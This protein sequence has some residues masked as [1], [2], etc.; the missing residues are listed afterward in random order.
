MRLRW[1]LLSTASINDLI[2]ESC[3]DSR[4]VE[5][6]AVASRQLERAQTYASARGIPRAFGSYEA[7]LADPDVDAIYV[8]LPNGLHTEWSQAALAAGKHV[9][10]EKP[11]TRHADEIEATYGIAEHAGRVFG[12][13]F[14]YRHHPQTEL[15]REVVA[16]GRLGTPRF[17]LSSHSFLM[18]PEE[19]ARRLPAELD[20]GAL[21]DLG[22][23]QIGMSRLLAGGEPEE[24]F[25]M[26]V[27]H[28][29]GV[30]MRFAAT[31]RFGG[32]LIAQFDCA[33]DV[34]LRN[35]LEVVGA[36]ATLTVSD[37]WHCRGGTIALR[38][39]GGA[40][41]QLAVPVGDAYRLEFEA[42]ARAVA[43]ERVAAFD[44][45]EAIAQARAIT[46][47][48]GSAQ[49]GTVTALA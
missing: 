39:E 40:V 43:G 27:V 28:E 35:A 24:V 18:P 13:A 20:A 29:T 5:V 11:L 23:Y 26:Q 34:P 36:E 32:G 25:G 48:Y 4:A 6:A 17:V 31:L 8:S 21:M 10:C 9:L 1:G 45:A 42:F 19:Y 16:S 7:L 47:L 41:E 49:L 22:C 37:P 15:I 44:R 14:M 30:D 46:A 3:R 2:L 33:M 12:E 38:R